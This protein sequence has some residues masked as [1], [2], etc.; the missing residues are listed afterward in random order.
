M[1]KL[2]LAGKLLGASFLV[3]ACLLTT[4][5]TAFSQA[6]AQPQKKVQIK[7][8]VDGKEIDLSDLKILE[9]IHGRSQSPPRPSPWT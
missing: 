3:A 7:I 4:A 2:S 6:Q 8:L 9:H 1:V 5:A